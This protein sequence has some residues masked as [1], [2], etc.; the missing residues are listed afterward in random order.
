MFSSTQSANCQ[1]RS[2]EAKNIELNSNLSKEQTQKQK[3]QKSS[4]T[5]EH[6]LHSMKKELVCRL[7]NYCENKEYLP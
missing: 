1:K 3:L 6:K 4:T 2:L 5:S 7:A